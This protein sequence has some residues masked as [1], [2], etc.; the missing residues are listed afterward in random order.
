MK[1]IFLVVMSV[2]ILTVLGS[3][4]DRLSEVD[5]N[6]ALAQALDAASSRDR[7]IS[8]DEVFYT[9]EQITGKRQI[10]T[11]FVG[12]DAKRIDVNEEFNGKKTRS[13][14]ITLNGQFFC[15]S[16]EKAW[17]RADKECAKAGKVMAIP[18]GEYEYSVE[19]DPAN[20]GW[21]IYT[22]RASWK[23]LGN[24]PVRDAA[25]LKFIEIKF[26][27]DASGLI[28]EYTETRRGGS[29]PNG[30]SSTQVTRYEYE[31]MGLKITEP[32]VSNKL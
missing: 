11:D 12:N 23:D 5:Y 25:R 16:G 18:D 31:P 14:S 6:T 8:T 32:T 19:A 28:T 7:R 21:K 9:G 3:A 30:W 13:N 26:I 27:T 20:S 1:T 2:A 24:S 17:R 4:Q 15:K 22:R 10:V 29:E